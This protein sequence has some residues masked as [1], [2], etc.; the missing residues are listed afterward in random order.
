MKKTMIGMTLGLCLAF[1]FGMVSGVGAFPARDGA[2][3][4]Y[5]RVYHDINGNGQYDEGEE[6]IGGAK[7]ATSTGEVITTDVEGYYSFYIKPQAIGTT[8]IVKLDRRSLPRGAS[9]KTENPVFTRVHAEGAIMANFGVALPQRERPRY[10]DSG[11][12]GLEIF[13]PEG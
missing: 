7:V 4:V 9:I 6:G 10:E 12:A 11:S 1:V 13:V 8:V 5:G 2:I 3:N